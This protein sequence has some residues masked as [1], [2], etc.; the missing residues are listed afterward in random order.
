MTTSA[1]SGDEAMGEGQPDSTL[2]AT[3][4]ASRCWT[5]VHDTDERRRRARTVS[6]LIVQGWPTEHCILLENVSF[7]S[8]ARPV[9]HLS[10]RC[11]ALASEVARSLSTPVISVW[12]LNGLSTRRLGHGLRSGAGSAQALTHGVYDAVSVRRPVVYVVV[13]TR[14]SPVTVRLDVH[15]MT[16]L[17]YL[18]CVNGEMSF[19]C[20]EDI[21]WLL[22]CT[23]TIYYSCVA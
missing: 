8:C 10:R 12:T 5:D 22:N 1:F 6:R 3:A 20:K 2:V 19:S 18:V 4:W 17:D 21:E 7:G 15:Y 23:A 16:K 14:Q 11:C 9:P 13:G